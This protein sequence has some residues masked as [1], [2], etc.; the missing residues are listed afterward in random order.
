[1]DAAQIKTLDDV[2]ELLKKVKELHPEMSLLVSSE[3]KRGPLANINR[4]VSISF[5]QVWAFT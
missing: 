5:S 3:P 2:E 4:G 1:M